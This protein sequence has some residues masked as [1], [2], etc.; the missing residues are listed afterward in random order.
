MFVAYINYVNH[1]RWHQFCTD[2]D[3]KGTVGGRHSFSAVLAKLW[4]V[5]KTSCH[6]YCIRKSRTTA[7]KNIIKKS[8][9]TL[10]H[11]FIPSQDEI[12]K[13]NRQTVME[14]ET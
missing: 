13:G 6:A 11:L 9:H 7:Y 12:A 1:Y 14:T 10:Y 2:I 5:A 8:K 4:K 3:K